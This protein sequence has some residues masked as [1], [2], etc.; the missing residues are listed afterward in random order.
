MGTSHGKHM[1]CTSACI[2]PPVTYVVHRQVLVVGDT[3]MA[4]TNIREL[5]RAIPP[6]LTRFA[7]LHTS[8]KRRPPATAHPV[9]MC[10]R[11]PVF[12]TLVTLLATSQSAHAAAPSATPGCTYTCT[13]MD[14]GGYPVR[15]SASGV[16][17]GVLHCDYPTTLSTAANI[18][19]CEYT[20]STGALTKAHDVRS[21]ANCTKV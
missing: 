17:N 20:P 2:I 7:A 18:Y 11:L 21:V 4:S 6:F 10:Y 3:Q 14:R 13:S 12:L 9:L 15:A 5:S 16:M 19:Y 8:N 1:C